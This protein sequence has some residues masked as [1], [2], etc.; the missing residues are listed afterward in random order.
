MRKQVIS[1]GA[2]VYC[3]SGQIPSPQ[4]SPITTDFIY[5]FNCNFESV[6]GPRILWDRDRMNLWFWRWTQNQVA[7]FRLSDSDGFRVGSFLEHSA[8]WSYRCNFSWILSSHLSE[9]M[10]HISAAIL[11]PSRRNSFLLLNGSSLDSRIDPSANLP[12]IKYPRAVH[13]VVCVPG[14]QMMLT[15]EF[16]IQIFY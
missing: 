15:A 11:L 7:K 6:H 13:S 16:D 10:T 5:H 12:E 3:L 9:H 1:N 8:E 2:R 4:L 14:N